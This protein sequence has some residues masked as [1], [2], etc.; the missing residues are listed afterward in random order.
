VLYVDVL[1]SRRRLEA[2]LS[3]DR[4][5]RSSASGD[6]SDVQMCKQVSDSRSGHCVALAS[7]AGLLRW[8]LLPGIKL[9]ITSMQQHR[10]KGK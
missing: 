4:W 3:M 10:S 8:G 1:I 7:T 2:W 6:V 5:C 9:H